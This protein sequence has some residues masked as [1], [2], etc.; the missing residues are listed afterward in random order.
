MIE[1]IV[2]DHPAVYPN[3]CFLCGSGKGPMV[4]THVEK[5]LA[6]GDQH[7]YVCRLCVTRAARVFGLVKGEKMDELLAASE[8]LE[9][10]DRELEA[11]LTEANGLRQAAA[12]LRATAAEQKA[13]LQH[14]A[15]VLQ[16]VRHQAAELER[17]AQELTQAA[18]GPQPVDVSVA[19]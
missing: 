11:L 15:G 10:K 13:Q 7:V 8:R 17:L 19:A 5:P 2:V 1:F 4:D 9:E 16:N 14:Q 3:A 12:G 18:V 6:G